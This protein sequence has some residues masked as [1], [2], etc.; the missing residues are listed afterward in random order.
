MNSME[1]LED[2]YSIWKRICIFLIDGIMALI[3]FAILLFA[4]GNNVIKGTCKN[5]IQNLNNEFQ[6]ICEENNYPFK[7][8]KL[9]G[10][11]V[12]D[13]DAWIAY[14]VD[15]QGLTPEE[16]YE[17]YERISS[18]V[19]NKLAENDIYNNAYKKFYA[20]YKTNIISCMFISLLILQLI[21][22]L[23]TKKRQTLTMMI[24]KASIVNKNTNIVAK[25]YQILLRF[26]IMFIVEFLLVYIFIESI[27]IIFVTL[28]TMALISF[29][30]NRSTIHDL[31]LKLK[32]K[33]S[34]HSYVE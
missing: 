9:Y 30:K 24:F 28:I 29:T 31:V 1:L 5:E 27:G 7:E 18:E 23:I 11:Y 13:H 21:W 14:C 22:P 2:R 20:V 19:D 26:L 3:L 32:I 8:E 25:N 17:S 12:I 16:A 15:E 4:L 33:D 34:S 10:L 6:N